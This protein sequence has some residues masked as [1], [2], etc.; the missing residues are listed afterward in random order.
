[1]RPRLEAHH[2]IKI[3]DAALETAL[4]LSLEGPSKRKNP[5]R[6]LDLLENACAALHL[7]LAREV[8]AGAVPDELRQAQCELESALGE[9]DLHRHV[10]AR[11]TLDERQTAWSNQQ[12]TRLR[13]EHILDREDV[14]AAARQN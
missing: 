9:L 3:S 13:H 11:A 4:I 1:M 2:C 7:R 5:D 14:R 6:A 8:E 10:A 12:A